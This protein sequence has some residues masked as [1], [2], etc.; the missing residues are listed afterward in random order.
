M[1]FT[2]IEM[3][4]GLA[5]LSAALIASYSTVS[6]AL[7]TASRLAERRV[8]VEAVQHEMNMLRRAPTIRVQ[9]IEGETNAYQWLFRSASWA[10]Y[11]A[12]V[13]MV[14]QKQWWIRLWWRAEHEKATEQTRRIHFS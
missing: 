3:L 14:T 9:S 5:I 7:K 4:V 8:A 13:S 11:L 2:L 12:R 1:G 6:G 10:N